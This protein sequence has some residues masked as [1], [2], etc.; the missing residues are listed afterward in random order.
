MNDVVSR[1]QPFGETIFATMSA[2]AAAAGAINLGQGFPDEDGPKAMLERAVAEIR[3]GNNQYAP[4]P[5]FPVLREAVARERQL[6]Y[7]QHVDPKTEVFITVGATEAIAATVLGLVEPGSDVI[8]LEPYYDSYAA[9]IA[10]AGA[11]R[12][13]VPLV[14]RGGSWDID[15]VA[16]DAAVTERTRMIIVNSPHNPTGSFLDVAA[17]ARVAVRHDLLVLADDVYEHLIFDGGDHTP[18]ATLPGMWERTVTVSSAAKTFNATGWKTGWAVAP[19]NLIEAVARAKQFMTFVG[20]S[21][22]Q[23]AV[24]YALDNEQEWV[25]SMVG[26]LQRKRDFL[27][28]RLADAGFTV[29]D[30]AGT[31]YIVA[32]VDRPGVEFSNW[33]IDAAGVAC[34][35]VEVFTDHPE[36][37]R[38]LVRFAFCKK[39]DVLEEAGTRLTRLA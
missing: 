33:L 19:A 16:L 10:L 14:S 5:G 37:W 13:A 3:S 22:F 29:H 21:P 31:Y 11:S 24:A 4:G 28:A 35:P 20:A 38:N 2:K 23:P 8:V 34:I 32:E 25:A 18:I 1:L 15:E 30:T 36:Q 39:W 26:E 9:A 12:V 7:G 17:V 6:R 27:A